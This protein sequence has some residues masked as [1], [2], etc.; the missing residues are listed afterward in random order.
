MTNGQQGNL[1]TLTDLEKA[2]EE[3]PMKGPSTVPQEVL[4]EVDEAVKSDLEK[5]RDL[6][7]IM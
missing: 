7:G 1:K 3:L 5:L 6:P 4:K 2:R